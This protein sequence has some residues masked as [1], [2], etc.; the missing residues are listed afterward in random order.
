LSRAGQLV[1]PVLVC[2]AKQDRARRAK[3]RMRRINQGKVSGQW[4][5]AEQRR[6]VDTAA[7]RDNE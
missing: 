1:M 4:Q 5:Q 2:P 7:E 6:D 3:G